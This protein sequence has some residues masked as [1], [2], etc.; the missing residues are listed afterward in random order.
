MYNKIFDLLWIILILTDISTD[1][2]E[3][4]Y[5]DNKYALKIIM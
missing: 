4:L 1:M 3:F 5:R 2:H